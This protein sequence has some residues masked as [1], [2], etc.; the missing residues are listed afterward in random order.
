MGWVN[1]PKV[2]IGKIGDYAPIYHYAQGQ[3]EQIIRDACYSQLTPELRASVPVTQVLDFG[4]ALWLKVY[5]PH[6]D[7]GT[8]WVDDGHNEVHVKVTIGTLVVESDFVNETIISCLPAGNAKIEITGTYITHAGQQ[9]PFDNASS[10]TNMPG[11]ATDNPFR[12]IPL[13]RGEMNTF[14]W[15]FGWIDDYQY[16]QIN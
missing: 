2:Q 14:S 12:Y 15:E 16:E 11:V 8:D 1:H 4:A 5:P 6:Y 13:K 9:I 10:L 7:N 3:D